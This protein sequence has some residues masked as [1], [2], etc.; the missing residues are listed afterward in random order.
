MVNLLLVSNLGIPELVAAVGVGNGFINMFGM[1]ILVGMNGAINTL[2]SQAA[3]ARQFNLCH[4]YLQRARTVLLI[5]LVP[6]SIILFNSE[7]ILVLIGQDKKVSELRPQ[8][9]TNP[10]ATAARRTRSGSS[11][12]RPGPC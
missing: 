2:V 1:S 10:T 3:G 4:L 6:V 7:Y 12:R 11:R 9:A 8:P 5:C